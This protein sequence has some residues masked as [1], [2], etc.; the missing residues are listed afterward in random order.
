[1]TEQ[2]GGDPP[3]KTKYYSQ[4]KFVWFL[5][6]NSLSI[7]GDWLMRKGWLTCSYYDFEN[8]FSISIAPIR[9]KIIWTGTQ[10][11]FVHLIK[12]LI[13]KRMIRREKDIWLFCSHHFNLFGGQELNIRSCASI[14]N[15]GPAYFVHQDLEELGI[16]L[17]K[18]GG[19]SRTTLGI[20]KEGSN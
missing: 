8:H 16:E 9:K 12:Y 1:M 18:N 6:Q 4:K 10:S 11:E 19:K 7:L 3:R 5:S 14:G 2:T 15:K 13:S 20:Y 17:T